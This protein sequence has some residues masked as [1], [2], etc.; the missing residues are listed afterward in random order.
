MLTF[1]QQLP[2]LISSSPSLLLTLDSPHAPFRLPRPRRGP[3]VPVLA[4]YVRS[5]RFNL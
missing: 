3:R 1:A 2:Q 4:S 5:N